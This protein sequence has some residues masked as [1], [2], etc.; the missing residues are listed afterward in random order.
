MKPTIKELASYC[1]Q[2]EI[3]TKIVKI[4][5]FKKISQASE[6][7]ILDLSE[8]RELESKKRAFRKKVAMSEPPSRKKY[9]FSNDLNGEYFNEFVDMGYGHSFRLL[10]REHLLQMTIFEEMV[11]FDI[12]YRDPKKS[13]SLL[14]VPLHDWQ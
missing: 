5:K 3:C 14:R 8:W 10:T 2:F 12:F 7:N 1:I 13:F 9:A 11:E 4:L 6:Q